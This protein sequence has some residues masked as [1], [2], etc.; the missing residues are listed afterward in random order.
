MISKKRMRKLNVMSIF[1]YK[2]K[3]DEDYYILY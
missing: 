3:K 1:K 2:N